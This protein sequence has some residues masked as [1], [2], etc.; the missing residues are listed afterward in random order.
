M[1]WVS[2]YLRVSVIVSGR[3]NISDVEK[4]YNYASASDLWVMLASY[5]QQWPLSWFTTT[6]MISLLIEHGKLELLAHNLIHDLWRWLEI[7]VNDRLGLGLQ[8]V[9]IL[10]MMITCIV[11]D[12]LARELPPPASLLAQSRSWAMLI[13][14]R[15]SCQDIPCCL[16]LEYPWNA[17]LP[18]PRGATL[19]VL[20]GSG[21]HII[22]KPDP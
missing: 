11:S 5:M 10:Q 13:R 9:M 20:W 17:D 8:L 6:G 7:Q 15:V 21:F 12:F 14:V 18:G 16:A 1:L 4:P 22:W 3:S 19:A 2:W